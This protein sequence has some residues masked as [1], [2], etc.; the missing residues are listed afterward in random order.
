MDLTEALDHYC[1]RLSPDFWAEPVNALSNLAFIIAALAGFLLW[2]RLPQRDW[3]ILGLIL[4]VL[5]TGIGSFLFHTIATRWAMLADVIPIAIFIHAYLLI[6]LIRVLGLRWW[7][8]L[9]ATVLF[10]FVSPYVG[11]AVQGIA[12]SSSG[13]VPALAALFVVGLAALPLER[14][15]GVSLCAIGGLFALSVTLRTL[16]SPLCGSLPLG[17]H[18]LWHI[19]NGTVLFSL[20]WVLISLKRG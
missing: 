12:G 11:G 13:Y 14:K 20:L 7:L 3:P 8:A 17:T 15:A 2:R 19:L 5:A 1:E 4:V 6:A 10:L 16:D 9:A 18:F